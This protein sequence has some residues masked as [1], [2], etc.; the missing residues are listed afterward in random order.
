MFAAVIAHELGHVRLLGEGRARP[1]DA[2]HEK[3]TD[4]VTVFLGMGVFTA[5]AANRFR[6]ARRGFTVLPA[7]ELTSRMLN[8][9][10]HDD[11][12]HHLGYLAASQFAYALACCAHLRGE[13]DPPWARHLEPGVRAGLNHGLTHLARHPLA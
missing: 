12:V 7:G 5:N 9:A 11:S 6:P 2:R 13:S 10:A 1:T 8:G 3:L 4:L